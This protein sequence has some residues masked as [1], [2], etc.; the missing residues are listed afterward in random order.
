MLLNA[1]KILHNFYKV[2]EENNNTYSRPVGLPKRMFE[3]AQA[4]WNRIWRLFEYR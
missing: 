1:L 3:F 4:V 2:D